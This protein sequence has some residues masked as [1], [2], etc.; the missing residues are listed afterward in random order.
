MGHIFT[1]NRKK[2]NGKTLPFADRLP[3]FL[4]NFTFQ[5]CLILVVAS[6]I[7]A[8]LVTPRT[9]SGIPAYTVGM[10]AS[11]D[12]KADRDLLVEDTAAT[13]QKKIEASK[14]APPVYEYTASLP[15]LIARNMT[16]AFQ[17]AEEIFRDM[18]VND[19][20]DSDE[21]RKM[22]E[23]IRGVF[24]A[25][26]G[27]ELNNEE[28]S[29]LIEAG[30][31]RPVADAATH[32][33][34]E[35]YKNP[36]VI[37]ERP[38]TALQDSGTVLI[39]EEGSSEETVTLDIDTIATMKEARRFLGDAVET[40]KGPL[41]L[42][43]LNIAATLAEMALR[44]TLVFSEVQTERNRQRMVD[45]VKPVF[46]KVLKNEMVVREGQRITDEDMKKLEMLSVRQNAHPLRMISL[47][48]GTF[49]LIA[50]LALVLYRISVHRIQ[51]IPGTVKNLV[52]M[53]FVAVVQIILVKAGIF[54]AEA[55]WP[56]LQTSGNPLVYA[57][58]FATGSMLV[59][60]LLG[61]R[62][63]GLIFSIFTSFCVTFLFP[64]K[65]AIFI[66]AFSGSIVASHFIIHCRKRSDFFK[67]GL[68]VGAL[69]LI[70]VLALVLF[71]G[72]LLAAETA[73]KL[74]MALS[75]GLLAGIIV[76][77]TVPLFE[78]LF[79][80]TT[81]I[82]LLELANL[83]QP[84]FQEMIIKAPGT[85]HHSIIV[86][87][88]VE[89]AAEEIGANSLLAKVGA[90]Y[91][92]I[93]K[94]KK[95]SYYIENQQTWEN[96]HDK[97]KPSMSS[98]VIISHVKEG[99]EIADAIKL[100]DEICNIIRQHHGTRLAVFFYEKAKKEQN[101][102]QPPILESD[103]RYPGP[104]PQSKEAALVLL[105]DIVEASSRIL[106]NPTP[107]RIKALI[108]T[109]IREAVDDDQLNESDLTFSDLNKIA[110]SFARILNGIFHHRIDYYETDGKEA[111]NEQK[112]SS[113][114]RKPAVK[115]SHKIP[116]NQRVPQ[117][118]PG[119]SGVH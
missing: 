21:R 99:C 16:D 47:L 55:A 68:I 20:Q 110:E 63:M 6:I 74:V 118:P 28:L 25:K 77:G 36:F 117:P 10:V 46:F 108:D 37:A 59:S 22:V 18:P 94:M 80:Y 72:T 53:A 38:A 29:L 65:A 73:L 84:I 15:L 83:N 48:M 43:L 27:I 19:E 45:D 23:T 93:G 50:I 60:V 33:L 14:E 109:R 42:G 97:L 107:S 100:G 113:L 119:A 111:S 51:S 102:S 2:T 95:P 13:Q 88:M 82:K 5:T 104:K 114:R 40:M 56:S 41:E 54:I 17:A 98:R 4:A 67:T 1:I 32:L 62:D 66:Y 105:A 71:G 26:T 89:A 75:G 34:L 96:K 64:D 12:I 30:F 31:A 35:A 7:L 116:E 103:F 11:K 24:K 57:I 81:D 39:H 69:N 44:P 76:S 91:H 78:Y 8:V 85:Y 86:A 9:G 49:L 79:G 87:S 3:S 61:S 90:Y 70:V 101:P 106:K 115:N 52:F 92:D 112:N 58:P